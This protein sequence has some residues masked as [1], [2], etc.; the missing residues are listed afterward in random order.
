SAPLA[1]TPL[2]E[3]AA[4][5][6]AKTLGAAHLDALLG[7]RDLDFFVLVSSVAGV[8]GSAGQSAY[9]AA[10]AYLDALAE[11]RRSRGL[12]ATSVAWGP[13]AE[14]GMASAHRSV[15]E[16]IERTGLRLLRPDT[17][18]AELRRAVVRG[19]SAVTVAD[20]D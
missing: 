6:A 20:V 16:G 1:A 12:T 3:V 14:V 11:N 18:M 15:S 7:D 2:D 13:W 17:A 19:E 9:A 5:M 8:W 10:N 4:T